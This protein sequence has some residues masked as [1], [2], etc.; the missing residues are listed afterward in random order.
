[1]SCHF[2]QAQCHID[3]AA[4]VRNFRRCGA[5]EK[6]MP[7]LKSDAYGHGLLE[8]ARSLGQAGAQR[9]AVGCASEGQA[10]REA[11]FAQDI[12]PLMP[13]MTEEEWSI[14]IRCGLIPLVC[15]FA[16]LEKAL[17][18]ARAEA[19]LPIAIKVETGMHR[20]GFREEEIPA[21]IAKLQA[22]PQLVP[23]MVVSHCSCADIP[24]R[25]ANTAQQILCFSSM[26]SALCAAF[27]SMLRSLFNSAG[28]L[29]TA[30]MC[31]ICDVSRPG[32]VLYGGNPFANTNEEALGA[33]FEWVM[34]LSTTILQVTEL[35]RG[36][37]VSYG[38]IYVA[39]RDM[40]L[41]VVAAGY[42]TGVQR[43][44]THKLEALVHG[45]RVRSVGRICMNMTMFDVTD[46]PN[47]QAGDDVWLIGG[48][49]AEGEHPVTP[50][51]WAEKLGTISY[52]IL[53]LL[54][55]LNPRVY[56]S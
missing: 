47:V 11:G 37:G 4:L 10:L 1:M 51:E 19:P 52:E 48:P 21:L 56:H 25:K 18:H 12:L 24:S 31:N 9:F 22:S 34:S 39:D 42:A 36:E 28:T 49:S 54:G 16:E 30:S 14:V 44:L 50:Q 15:S 3:L 20:L 7:V 43:N 17:A 35:R 29:D 8:V 27:P 13:P 55:S 5:P 33:D 32:I 40:R 46:L 23:S 2:T 45:H 26:A 41:A 38:Q 53:C 6:L